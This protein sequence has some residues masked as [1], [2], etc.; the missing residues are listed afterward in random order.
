MTSLSRFGV[1]ALAF[2]WACE[3]EVMAPPLV[4]APS[5]DRAFAVASTDREALVA[6]YN[7]TDGSNWERKDNWLTDAPLA[8]WYG[9][10]ANSQGQVRWLR[11]SNNGLKGPV[12]PELGSLSALE[13]LGLGE[14]ELTGEVPAE[15][16]DATRLTGLWI[17]DN[18]LTGIIPST[19]LALSQLRVL[20]LSG[21]D[22]LC[23]PS[24]ARFSEWADSLS[25]VSGPD[26]SEADAEVLRVLYEATG[27]DPDWTN[28]S[29]WLS[30]AALS[31]WHGVEVDSAG[32]V[33]R[34]DLSANGLSGQ[35][36]DSLAE[37]SVLVSLDLSDN[38][39]SG[40]LPDSLGKLSALTRLDV[41][42]NG[43]LAGRLPQSLTAL[44][45]DE[46]RYSNTRLCVPEDA[47]FQEW[48]DGIREHEGSG[49]QCP[50]TSQYDILAAIYEATNGPKWGNNDN[51]L[52]DAPLGEWYGVSTD[53][54]GQVTRLDLG[55]NFLQGQIP[56]EI[57][58]LSSLDHLRLGGSYALTGPLPEELYDLP[59]LRT[60][61]L[62]GFNLGGTLP[63]EIARLTQ[64]EQLYLWDAGLGGPLPT[65]ITQLA[66]LR[67]LDLSYNDL[68]GSIPPEFG[69]LTELDDLD[70][71]Y[72]ELA[73]GIPAE[74]GDLTNLS[75]LELDNNR[76]DGTIPEELA[77]LVNLQ[78]LSLHTNDLEG[79]IP[80]EFGALT[81]LE[82]LWLAL[83]PRL[84]GPLPDSLV[85]LD[86]LESLRAG[87]TSLCAPESEEFL[88]WLNEIEFHRVV[89]CELGATVYLTQPAQSLEFPVPL[90]AG[91]S[92]LLRAFVFS[93]YAAG[94]RMP[95]VR[96]TFYIND[97]Q[98]HTVEI[99]G[100]SAALPTEFDESSLAH[101]ANADIPGEVL[102]P[103]LEMVIEV[104]PE[105]TLGLVLGMVKRMPATGRLAVD[106]R[107]MPDFQLT[108]V[109]FLYE[110][111]PDSSILE[112][113]AGMAN[114]PEGHPMFKDTRALL[115]IGDFDVVRHDPVV[116]STDDGVQL[117]RDTEAIRLMEGRPGYWL[118]MLSP[119][120]QWGLLGV[121]NGIGS[122][123]SFSIPLSRTIAHE[124]GHN[125]NLRHAPCGGAGGPDPLFPD[126]N[127]RIGVWGY[128]RVSGR[129]LSPY[130]TDL[131]SYCRGG[132]ISGYHVSNSL[133]HRL[134][135]ETEAS[136]EKTRSVIVWGGRDADG[137][138]FLEPAF[139][140]NAIPKLPPIGREFQ[141]R[142]RTAGGGE[143]FSFSFD[144]PYIPDVEDGRSSFVF[145]VPVTWTD[146][147]TSISLA[148]GRASV[149]LDRAS[150]SPLTILR[151]P[152]TGQVRALLREPETAAMSAFGTSEAQRL[153]VLFSRGIPEVPERRR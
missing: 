134:D 20:D 106:V 49:R 89:R 104:D 40:P 67:R 35:L 120:P 72:N 139:M 17:N 150:Y 147:L 132:W 152:D 141:L 41:S 92:A 103:G 128:D 46:L 1:L 66:N 60:L 8:E 123:T 52:T 4:P 25:Q 48:L 133:I 112:V 97:E 76:L 109:P 21:N 121:A 90:V 110:A 113:T 102:Q 19:F 142:G 31:E 116:T 91:R 24:T 13:F 58:G 14:N 140:V 70:L 39:L 148:G 96:A 95:D 36:P 9:V 3:D 149:A 10:V 136:A 47:E 7:A 18:R 50:P 71:R 87:G 111:E 99:E 23:I 27:G 42:G 77:K 79:P 53:S 38:T 118:A 135:A 129:L 88:A 114:D 74:L 98:V 94:Q 43:N 145:A 55:W 37:L 93:P 131:M 138:L 63:P 101:S 26:C 12:V 124:F 54:D 5:A 33:S 115:P 78:T 22:G 126:G 83:N 15:L 143:A 68:L 32:R 108:L 153:E 56:S 65:E 30:D 119:A 62:G 34:L 57:G 125:M 130:A 122:W 86:A 44:G 16:A 85:A 51:W 59:E 6:L 69:K 100:G 84:S 107:E 45:L 146:A 61:H 117:M 105:G 73:G 144:M 2:L 29:G 127:G 75:Q 11:L 151:D 64:L 80:A 81:E 137:E 82:S 28:S